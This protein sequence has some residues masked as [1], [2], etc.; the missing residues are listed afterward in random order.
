M[1]QE[2]FDAILALAFTAVTVF[3]T[4]TVYKVV[5]RAALVQ[6]AQGLSPMVPFQRA[7]DGRV[8]DWER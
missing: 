6:V 5:K 7:I 8:Y 2:V 3:S 4:P 1:I